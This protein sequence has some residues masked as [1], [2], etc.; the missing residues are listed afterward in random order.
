MSDKQTTRMAD[1]CDATVTRKSRAEEIEGLA[2]V[3]TYK[4]YDKD[5][6]FKWEDTSHNTVMTIGANVLLDAT[7]ATT[8]YTAV[9]P[10]LGILTGAT[11][12]GPVFSTADTLTGGTAGHAGWLEV[13]NANAPALMSPRPTLLFAVAT[14]RSKTATT[15][16][17]TASGAGTAKGSFLVFFTGASAT[18]DST[19]GT[20]FSAGAFTGG[21]KL[22]ATGDT[23]QVTWSLTAT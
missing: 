18:I 16:S 5:G 9:G 11:A 20:L 22:L 12:G 2:G 14:A 13:G 7:F 15:A 6:N 10:F 21:D 23:L 19:S 1:T 4:C 8:A 3:Y 17:V